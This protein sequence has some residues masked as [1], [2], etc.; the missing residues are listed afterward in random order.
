MACKLWFLFFSGELGDLFK[1]NFIYPCIT[2]SLYFL[3][4]FINNTKEAWLP[5]NYG[6]I[7]C[8]NTCVTSLDLTRICNNSFI[9]SVQIRD[10]GRFLAKF[11]PWTN[12]FRNRLVRSQCLRIHPSVKLSKPILYTCNFIVA[13]SWKIALRE[14]LQMNMS[15][16]DTYMLRQWRILYHISHWLYYMQLKLY[17]QKINFRQTLVLLFHKRYVNPFPVVLIM[18]LYHAEF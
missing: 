1:W 17:K 15:S 6:R 16:P 14:L 11:N 9:Y 13:V 4:T 2:T 5:I 10:V 18:N 3:V 8:V 12:T 7:E